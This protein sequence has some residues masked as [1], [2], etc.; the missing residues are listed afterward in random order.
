METFIY[1][2]IFIF[3]AIIG[4]FLNVV[5]FR[6]H[7]GATF[8]GR[9]LCFSCGKTLLWHDLVPVLSFAALRGKCRFCRS[10][11][12]FEYAVVEIL[13]GALFALMFWKTGGVAVFLSALNGGGSMLW[14]L[15]DIFSLFAI[16][17]LLLVIGGYDIKHKIVP[18]AFVYGF[19]GL[20]FLRL[21]F[22]PLLVPI[23][24][25]DFL[26]GPILALPFAFLWHISDGKWMGFGDAKIALGIGWFLGLSAGF[27]AI[28]LAFWI[29]AVFGLILIAFGKLARSSFFE[30]LFRQR[31]TLK[32]EIPFAPFLIV[33]LL[34]TL[35]V[36]Q[37]MVWANVL[38]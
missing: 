11:I 38:Y 23:S 34:L 2:L 25:V 22:F 30:S 6:Y 3:G 16:G 36:S 12:S 10:K 29:G 20:A 18:D 13:A 9:S 28:V 37:I 19:A 17:S 31:I 14:Y 1:F 21:I 27:T 32:S 7:S 15:L 33:G 8:L 35:F 24:P 5:I 4:S 26:A